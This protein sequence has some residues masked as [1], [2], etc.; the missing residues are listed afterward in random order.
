MTRLVVDDLRSDEDD[1]ALRGALLALINAE[2][3]R[4]SGA[5][6]DEHLRTALAYRSWFEFRIYVTDIATPSSR[7]LLTKKLGL[8]QGEQRVLSYLALFA[9]AASHYDSLRR[10]SPSAPRLLLLDDAFAKVDER[11]HAE[12]LGHLAALDLD[13]IL[14][15]ERLWGCFPN[16]PSLEIYEAVRDPAV[17]GVALV[18]YR[19]DG[20]ERHLVG[21]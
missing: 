19:W 21:V 16:V 11:T 15:S 18:H 3:E 8:S 13:Y 6:Y 5:G 1:E 12:L 2:R 14:T 7:R 10:E 4:D 9:A 20:S 17:P